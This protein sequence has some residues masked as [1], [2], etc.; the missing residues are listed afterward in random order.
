MKAL[1]DLC[2]GPNVDSHAITALQ[3]TTRAVLVS[4]V[5][6]ALLRLSGARTFGANT[7][8]DLVVKIMLGA[9]LSRAVVAASP[10]GATLL[11]SLALVALHRLLAWAAFHSD[12]IGRL[13]KGRAQV[14]AADGQPDAEALRRNYISEHD[15]R[16]GLRD[17]GNV[18]DLNAAQTVR[19]ERNGRISVVK[20]STQ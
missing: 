2:F 8:F 19:L 13:I 7:A 12:F 11:A 10:F 16:E 14:L 6:L 1:L 18:D 4:F 17:S 3:M 9:V 5:A 20:K 15:L